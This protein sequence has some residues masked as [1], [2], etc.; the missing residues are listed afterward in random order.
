MKKNSKLI[1]YVLVVLIVA[2]LAAG[3]VG[4]YKSLSIK[5]ND[6][7]S[8]NNGNNDKKDYKV[9]Y[10]Y[11]LDGIESETEIKDEKENVDSENFEGASESKRLYSF[12]KYTCSNDVSGQWNDEEWKF[13]PNLTA[14]TTCRLYFVKNTHEIKVIAVNATVNNATETVVKVEKD[15]ETNVAMSP[16]PGYKYTSFDCTNRTVSEYNSETNTLVIKSATKDSECTVSY[17]VSAYTAEIK[18]QNGTI[19]GKED[20]KKANYGEAITFTVLPSENYSDPTIDCTNGQAG[21]YSGGKF[22]IGAITNDTVCTISF[23]ISKNK[24]TLNVENGTVI[25]ADNLENPNVK[26]TTNNGVV[27]FGI[28]KNDG[29]LLTNPDLSCDD[30]NV[31][32]SYASGTITITSVTKDTTCSVKLKK[33]ETTTPDNNT[34]SGEGGN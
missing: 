28:S 11:Y 33:D 7:G 1:M 18:V 24:V 6:P 2:C 19:E 26:E 9:V 4:Y 31:K 34:G 3:G 17:A 23:R 16:N 27:T 21:S 5:P 13:T 20:N 30:E 22:T 25:N 29:Y 8:N 15:K 14:D 32:I 10:K 12:D